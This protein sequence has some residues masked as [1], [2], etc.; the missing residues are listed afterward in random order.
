MAEQVTDLNISWDGR[1]LIIDADGSATVIPGAQ[2]RVRSLTPHST[3]V[4]IVAAYE[5]QNLMV[6][7]DA[8]EDDGDPDPG[9]G[10]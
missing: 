2:V 8:E 1:D 3:R 9:G 10:S 7:R 6:S 5:A 4:E